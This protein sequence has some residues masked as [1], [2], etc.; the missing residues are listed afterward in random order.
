M[1]SA[2]S[3][4]LGRLRDVVAANGSHSIGYHNDM[5]N[6]DVGAAN[7]GHLIGNPNARAIINTPS[8]DDKE[9]QKLVN[10]PSHLKPFLLGR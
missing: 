1:K 2:C 3:A 10:T 5:S 9:I 4:V 7:G 8:E 6:H